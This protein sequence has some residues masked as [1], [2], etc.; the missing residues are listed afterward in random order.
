MRRRLRW[1]CVLGLLLY[2]L[3]VSRRLSGTVLNTMFVNKALVYWFLG[4]N[5]SLR[6]PRGSTVKFVTQK[7][8]PFYSLQA[9]IFD[10]YSFHS[11]FCFSPNMWEVYRYPLR[12]A[13][14]AFNIED[15]AAPMT[16]GKVS[17]SQHRQADGLTVVTQSNKLEVKDTAL[18]LAHATDADGVSTAQ[19]AVETR[20]GAVGLVKDLDGRGRSRGAAEGDGLGEVAAEGL[21]DLLGGRG[22]L[23]LEV[24]ADAGGVA[25][26]DG[27][28]VAGSGDAEGALLDKGRLVRADGAEDLAGLSLELILLARDEGHDVVDDVHG[29]HARVAGARDG[30]H[31]DDGDGGDGTEGGLEGGEGDDEADDGTV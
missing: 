16:A 19:V 7:R 3:V 1:T 29:G 25:V 21:L 18:V 4:V 15:P 31:G 27:D 2:T 6:K 14:S 28:A 23:A 20:L 8:M 10:I 9:V 13:A 30:L 11:P 22:G 26:H 17:I 5:M 24:E 12:T